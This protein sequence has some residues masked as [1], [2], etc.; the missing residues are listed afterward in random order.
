MTQTNAHASF[1][2]SQAWRVPNGYTLRAVLAANPFNVESASDSFTENVQQ[3]ENPQF[4]ILSSTP[5]TPEGQAVTIS[6]VLDQAGTSNPVA[7]EPVTLYAKLAGS[8]SQFQAIDTTHTGS[9][10]GYS[11]TASPVYNTVYYVSDTL[12]PKIRSMVLFQGVQDQLTLDGGSQNAT[13][14]SSMTLTGTVTPNKT[15]S[16]I[17]LQELGKDGFWHNVQYSTVAAGSTYSFTVAFGETG[18]TVLRVHISGD[19]SNVGDNTPP[20]SVSVSGTAPV[21]SLPPA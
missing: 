9:N 17:S 11:F 15:G 12:T 19:P 16:Q 20:L 5:I 1:S 2:V 10:G 13:L 18:T 7:N 8:G 3:A 21:S 14:G 4:T 6:G